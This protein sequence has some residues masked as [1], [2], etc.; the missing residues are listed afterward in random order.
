MQRRRGTSA[1]VARIALAA[2]VI[3]CAWTHTD[4]AAQEVGIAVGAAA[5][6]VEVQDLDGASIRLLDLIEPGRPA[7]LEFWA[8][9]CGEC[10][11]LQPE[12]DP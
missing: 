4:A 3:T 12:L 8:V 7:L 9:W 2:I 5:P 1:F 10:A 11:A 6:D